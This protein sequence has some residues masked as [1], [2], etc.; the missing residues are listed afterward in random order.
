M[1]TRRGMLLGTIGSFAGAA[2]LSPATQA[3]VIEE[4]PADVSKAL[5]AACRPAADN[6]ASLLKSARDDLLARIAK[7]LLP[8]GAS[9]QVGCPVCGCNF[10][11]SADGAL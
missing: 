11:V 5:A 2:L 1:M 8:M 10:I 6:H 3:F 4:I 9:E 7:G